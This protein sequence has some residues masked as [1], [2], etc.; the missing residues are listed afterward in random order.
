MGCVQP[1]FGRS[2]WCEW[3]RS[4]APGVACERSWAR[5]RVSTTA[6]RAVQPGWKTS[7]PLLR[8]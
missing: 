8:C 1:A 5:G 3:S 4:R 2:G 7:S 6:H